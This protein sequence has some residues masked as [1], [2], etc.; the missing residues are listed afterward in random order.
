MLSI[1]KSICLL[2]IQGILINVEVDVS[3]GMPCWD[4]VGLPDTSIKESKERVRTAIK[5]CGIKLLSKKY[6][7]NLSP[8]NIRKDGAVLDLAIAVGV[9]MSIGIIKKQKL[10]K[11]IFIGELSLDGKVNRI[12]GILPICIEARNNGMKKIFV[13]K[14]NLREARLVK[15]IEI[16]GITELKEIIDIIN[17]NKKIVYDDEV[18]NTDELSKHEIDFCDVK[19]HNF[20]KKA[21]EISASR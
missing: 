3:S 21:L 12:N 14:E 19:G 9:L 18:I 20:A 11:T 17:Y 4:I 15:D 13:P 10:E 7:I 16:V 1:T 5:N 8:A 6:I 2:G